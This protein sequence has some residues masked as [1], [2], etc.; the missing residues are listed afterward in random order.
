MKVYLI[1]LF[2]IFL[3]SLFT[4][5]FYCKYSRSK[6]IGQEIRLEGPKS[7][8]VKNKTPV[9][10]GIIFVLFFIIGSFYFIKINPYNIDYNF[11]SLI[12]IYF[13]LI[14]NF[15]IG[16][17]D[18]L[19][20]L[21]YHSNEGIS[22]K[23]KFLLQLLCSIVMYLVLLI[24]NHD[25]MINI[26]GYKVDLS[27]FYYFFCIFLYLAFPNAVNL[28]DGL[29]GLASG[30][31]IIIL[32]FLILYSKYVNNVLV[33]N[34]CLIFLITLFSFYLFNIKKAW[35]FMGDTGSLSI[36]AFL[37]SMLILLK[38]EILI[39]LMGFI[40]IVETLSVIIQVLYFKI[41]K[42]KRIFKMAPVHHH[43]ELCGFSENQINLIFYS[44]TLILC[45][46]A[47]SLGV[48]I[49]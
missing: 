22:P 31:T 15:I 38:I 32:I 8:Y 40:F 7:H 39:L 46:T 13:P 44:I 19:K 14:C 37:C 45:Y 1:I 28:T 11:Y 33:Y 9:M 20:I 26:F 16:L 36:G 18:D 10:G 21:K 5:Y 12:I 2:V 6:H 25:T 35:I 29:D 23:Y 24:S 17:I 4:Y 30:I 47:Y 34:F 27:I 42:G 48:K 49:F 3:L 43:L 41:T